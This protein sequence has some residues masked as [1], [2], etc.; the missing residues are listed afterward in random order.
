[1][2]LR[3]FLAKDMNE[4]LASV[5]ADMGDDAVIITRRSGGGCGDFAARI[6]RCALP[7]GLGGG[8]RGGRAE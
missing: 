1:M 4:A 2:Q 6:L 8:L 5:R 3:T 7:L